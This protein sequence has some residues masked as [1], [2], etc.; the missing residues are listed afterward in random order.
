MVL[1][2][3]VAE[4]HSVRQVVNEG[5]EEVHAYVGQA[6]TISIPFN[7]CFK[8]YPELPVHDSLVKFL[9][10]R[11]GLTTLA[12][13]PLASEVTQTP[14]LTQLRS[15]TLHKHTR[16]LKFKDHLVAL[17]APNKIL[18]ISEEGKSFKLTQQYHL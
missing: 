5:R 2:I 13:Y 16:I 3:T 10:T 12:K 6:K 7:K 8:A 18:I 17:H 14:L 1:F 15:P 4:C 9:P 11:L